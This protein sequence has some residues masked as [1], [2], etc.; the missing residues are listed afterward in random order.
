MSLSSAPS[1]NALKARIEGATLPSVPIY[2][3]GHSLG[4][5]L[6]QIAT[7]KFGSDRVA[8]CY[9]F[10]S[11]RVGSAFFDLWVKPPSYRVVNYADL[12]PQITV[13]KTSSGPAHMIASS[14]LAAASGR[15]NTGA[16]RK[17]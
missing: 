14:P 15:P 3:I 6:A 9:T 12:V 11:P 10:G 5:A 1:L 7:A 13:R 16:A 4:G 17:R 2:F 8:A